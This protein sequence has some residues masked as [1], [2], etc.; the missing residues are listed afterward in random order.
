MENKFIYLK[1]TQSDILIIN[2]KVADGSHRKLIFILG[3]ALRV[4]CGFPP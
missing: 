4:H 1:E 3:R 2:L